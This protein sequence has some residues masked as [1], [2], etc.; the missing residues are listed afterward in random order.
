VK[1]ALAIADPPANDAFA[2]ASPMAGMAAT[3]QSTTAN[4][5][6]EPGE[7]SHG[8]YQGGGSVWWTW[9]APSDTVASFD[10]A[11]SA[12]TTTLA[13][14]TGAAVSGLARVTSAAWGSPTR[15]TFRA[16]AGTTYRSPSIARTATPRRAP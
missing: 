8:G 11:G 13:V 16:V 4:A 2:G 6:K 14:Y 9:T 3:A 5:S 7:P 15:V 10:T 1:L 12:V